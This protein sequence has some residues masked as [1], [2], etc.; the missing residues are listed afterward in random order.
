MCKQVVVE[1]CIIVSNGRTLLANLVVFKVLGFDVIFG[2]DWLLKHYAS[3]DYYQNE[4]TFRVFLLVDSFF[5][6][7]SLSVI[8]FHAY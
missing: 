3:I 2:M 8:D 5:F 1:D 7:V 6:F 4:V